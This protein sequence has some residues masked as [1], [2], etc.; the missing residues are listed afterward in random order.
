MRRRC[1]LAS[2]NTPPAEQKASA[3]TRQEATLDE[4]VIAQQQAR[5]AEMEAQMASPQQA[6]APDPSAPTAAPANPAVTPFGAEAIAQTAS[7][8]FAAAFAQKT[9][10]HRWYCN[11]HDARE[12]VRIVEALLRR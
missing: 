4:Q 12:D 7:Q 11:H 9:A 6:L 8:A 5:V 3:Q 10:P 2:A 1:T